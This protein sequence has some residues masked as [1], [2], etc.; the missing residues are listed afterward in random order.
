MNQPLVFRATA[1]V[2]LLFALLASPLP[3]YALDI[4]RASAEELTQLKG[5]GPKR[6]EAIVRYRESHG[7]FAS[8]E[9]LLAVPGVGPTLLRDNEKHIELSSGGASPAQ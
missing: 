1:L 9:D 7:P 2:T 8:P 5:I 6:A 4:N 3:S